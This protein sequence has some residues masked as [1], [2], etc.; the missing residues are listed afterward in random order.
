LNWLKEYTDRIRSHLAAGDESGLTYAA[1]EARLALERVCY[2]RLR[3]SHDY[4][5]ADD[6]RRW[7]PSYIVQTL[8][9]QVDPKIAS[10]W[11]LST[12]YEPG[13]NP[14]RYIEIGTQKG[15]DPKTINL[16]WQAMSS[17]LHCPV[18]RN[19]KDWLTHYRPAQT[20]RPKIEEALQELD[21][22]AEG[23]LIGAMVFGE[24]SFD[25]VCGQE[26]RRATQ[27]LTHNQIVNCIREGCTESYRVEKQG[28]DFLFERRK[29]V[30]H[31]HSCNEA[32]GFPYRKLA[33]M[34]KDSHCIFS[35]KKCTAENRLIWRLG[36]VK[37][38]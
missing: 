33:E 34:P 26:N 1:L 5:S 22:I 12:G 21:R 9:E 29:L 19:S 4:I 27:V 20:M 10:E 16:L 38:K 32:I 3:T 36:Y 14:G 23:S 25:C 17:F 24:V 37:S 7:K 8:M 11:T 18:P 15:F 13:D 2:E 6:L 31:C 30:V 35:C 28:D